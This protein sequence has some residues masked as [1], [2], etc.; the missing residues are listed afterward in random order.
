MKKLY[1]LFILILAG[2]FVFSQLPEV[3]LF[4]D[5]FE[6]GSA[7]WSLNTSD[8]G[9]VGSNGANQWIINNTYAGGTYNLGGFFPVT[10]PS[11]P[12]QPA[13]ITNSPQSQYLHIVCG[14]ALADGVGN[15]NFVDGFSSSI[16]GGEAGANF[17]KMNVG[18]N[19]SGISD[20]TLSFWWLCNGA[21]GSVWYSTDGG[22]SWKDLGA[23]YTN[24]SNWTFATFVN[25]EF[26][27]QADLRFAFMF[28]NNVS[29]G[30]D[31]AFSVDEVRMFYTPTSNFSLSMSSTENTKCDGFGFNY[32]GPSILI[33]EV[34]LS[35]NTGDGSI[36]SKSPDSRGGE[37]IELYNPD[38]CQSIDISCYFLGNNAKIKMDFSQKDF[39]EDM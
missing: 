20:V 27:N 8:M 39:P 33:N 23:N 34:M 26:D 9:S 17:A 6:S 25:P 13:Q 38:R 22:T 18:I 3:E 32:D 4:Y 30:D 24:V 7:N 2:Q 37:W 11:T 10:I 5:N 16:V 14:A 35:P 19:T 12:N 36:Y 29:G 28:D 1:L 15:A 31:P 21:K